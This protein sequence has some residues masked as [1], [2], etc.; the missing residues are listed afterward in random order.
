[1]RSDAHC[2][3]ERGGAGRHLPAGARAHG[4]AIRCRSASL[5]AGATR[6]AAAAL[7]TSAVWTSA[8]SGPPAAVGFVCIIHWVGGAERK[9]GAARLRSL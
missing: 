1:V 3:A 8:R 9:H 5:S 4:L 2:R 6:C 7:W